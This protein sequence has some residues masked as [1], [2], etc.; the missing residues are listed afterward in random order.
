MAYLETS[1]IQE[2]L[3]KL[4]E[5]GTLLQILDQQLSPAELP[6][7][8]HPAR[9]DFDEQQRPSHSV[10][11]RE[12]DP[13]SDTP[14]PPTKTGTTGARPAETR[15]TS[16]PPRAPGDPPGRHKGVKLPFTPALYQ[17]LRTYVR[18]A[19][20]VLTP[21]NLA[22]LSLGVHSCLRAV[23]LLALLVGDVLD[24]K[25]DPLDRLT[26]RQRKTG[27]DV[28]VILPPAVQ[29]DIRT[30]RDH[31][32]AVYGDAYTLGRPLFLSSQLGAGNQPQSLSYQRYVHMLKEWL[33]A[34]GEDPRRYGTHS[35][36]STLPL[37]YYAITKD[38]I[39]SQQLL[40]HESIASTFD[41]L[42]GTFTD[43]SSVRALFPNR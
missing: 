32:L 18:A 34:V 29:A 28:Y 11:G 14:T 36:R 19:C 26:V 37:R 42:K 10:A 40:G 25:G 13:D 35:L 3:A 20:G 43:T 17:R 5:N 2:E 1:R 6:T 23:D 9:Q 7:E 41:Y 4:E 31:D 8:Q 16:P 39:G 30:L 21:R 15:P 27:N 24:A 38:P 12:R 22:L 33:Q